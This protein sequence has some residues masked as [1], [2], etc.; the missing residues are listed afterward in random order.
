MEPVIF[1]FPHHPNFDKPPWVS[2][3]FHHNT[4]S[5]HQKRIIWNIFGM[6]TY[7]GFCP[8]PH[9]SQGIAK[10]R[11]IC[12]NSTS[13][14]VQLPR[15]RSGCREGTDFLSNSSPSGTHFT[16]FLSSEH[17]LFA[18]STKLTDLHERR[19][20]RKLQDER[21]GL[22]S[23]R[24]ATCRFKRLREMSWNI[25]HILYEPDLGSFC[26]CFSWRIRLK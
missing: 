13:S 22:N 24:R 23:S 25:K 26:S 8:W 12:T 17:M 1:P 19:L 3:N 18:T 5:A 4:V 2:F 14:N 21:T 15:K 7:W 6:F 20:Q 16:P 11:Q 9:D 10:E